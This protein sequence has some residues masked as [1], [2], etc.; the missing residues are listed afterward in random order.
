MIVAVEDDM[1]TT[2]PPNAINTLKAT[3]DAED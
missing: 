2:G 1:T 3:A